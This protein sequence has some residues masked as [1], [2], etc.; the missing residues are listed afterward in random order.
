MTL[1]P[2][3]LPVV[4]SE[5]VRVEAPSGRINVH[6]RIWNSG[7]VVKQAVERP[8]GQFVRL[9]HRHR[10]DH[11]KPD[12][13]ME[14]MSHPPRLD[15]G[16]T[17]DALECSHGLGGPSDDV[18]MDRIEQALPD[19]DRSAHQDDEWGEHK[20]PMDEY[21]ARNRADQTSF[22]R[23]RVLECHGEWRGAAPFV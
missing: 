4:G 8:F 2:R 10:S 13:R 7:H 15:F 23:L 12:L 9:G 21:R 19:R 22:S 16:H 14:P 5:L 3:G 18:R 1:R 20:H 6:N 11:T 17:L